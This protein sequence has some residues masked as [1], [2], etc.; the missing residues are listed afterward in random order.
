MWIED[1]G[2]GQTL[3]VYKYG[4]KT[5]LLFSLKKY[6]NKSDATQSAYQWSTQIGRIEYTPCNKTAAKNYDVY[7]R[8]TNL[9]YSNKNGISLGTVERADA[10]I[11]LDK[12]VILIWKQ[13][14]KNNNRVVGSGG[15]TSYRKER[16]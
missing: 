6:Y 16:K 10:S 12:S 7:K 14:I 8:F 5:Y 2:H 13:C 11:S 15:R 1:A 9:N 3:E 4:T